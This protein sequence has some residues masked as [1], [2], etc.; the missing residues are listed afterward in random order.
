MS[1]ELSLPSYAVLTKAIQK[2][3]PNGHA[4]QIHG[5]LCG[6]LCA[7]SNKTDNRWEEFVPGI[8]NNKK[9]H[10]LLKEIIEINYQQLSEFSFEFNL[11]L[12]KEKTDINERAEALG[13]WCQ[14]FLTGLDLADISIQSREPG[15]V[16]EALNDMMEISEIDFG[17]IAQNDEDESAY[18]ELVEYVRLS[19]VMIFHELKTDNA[20][21]IIT[22]NEN[23]N[24]LL[25]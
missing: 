1:D 18:Y 5:L 24:P 11:I 2:I 19:V 8:K 14:G 9:V 23:E 25:H 22:E 12:P 3:Q 15:Q 21:T 20:P 4:A 13:L 16:S 6:I 7:H 17:E 10:D